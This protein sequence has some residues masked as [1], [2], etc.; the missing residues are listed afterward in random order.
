MLPSIH[1]P[2]VE[3][4]PDQ[5]NQ[6]KLEQ[7]FED[8]STSPINRRLAEIGRRRNR[9]KENPVEIHPG[10]G[11]PLLWVCAVHCTVHQVYGLRGR[12]ELVVGEL[13]TNFT[14]Q[15]N[16]PFGGTNVN[17][18]QD[19]AFKTMIHIHEW[20]CDIDSRIFCFY[21]KHANPWH[22]WGGV[23]LSVLPIEYWY[24]LHGGPQEST[25]TLIKHSA[26]LALTKCLYANCVR[27][28]LR[29][30]NIFVG[31]EYWQENK[32]LEYSHLAHTI[33]TNGWT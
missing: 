24:Q 27:Y 8:S 4:L 3:E 28:T 31:N 17:V 2:Q 6:V 9:R 22:R 32:V 13:C 25:A 20:P 18:I 10:I 5:R 26:M 12:G 7:T 29:I 19:F 15:R 30:P 33:G 14:T 1:I 16:P 11:N 23:W 21:G